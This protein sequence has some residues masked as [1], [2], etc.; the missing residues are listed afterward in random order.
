MD[1]TFFIVADI[2]AQ[3]VVNSRL[4]KAIENVV[5]IGEED[6]TEISDSMLQA[7]QEIFAQ[8]PS[9]ND[10]DLSTNSSVE[11]ILRSN[12]FVEGMKSYWTVDPIDGTKG[13]IRGDQYCVC[14]AMIDAR[15]EKPVLSALACPNLPLNG[16]E[17]TGLLMISV[18]SIG[19]FVCKIGE[20]IESLKPLPLISIHDDLSDAIFTGAFVS[21]HTNPLEVDGIKASFGNELPVAR[22]DSQCKYGLLALGRAHVYYRRHASKDPAARKDWKCDYVEAIWDNAPGY[23]FVKEAGGQVTDFDGKDLKFPPKKHFTITG[24]ILASMLTPELHQKVISV[25]QERNPIV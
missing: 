7:I 16:E 24:G 9:L 11:T 8:F 14:I 4:E 1:S 23:L 15:T 21:S 2:S 20:G 10:I 5:I 3:I 18:A 25:V 13:F 6:A 12:K 22:M 19:N 17:E